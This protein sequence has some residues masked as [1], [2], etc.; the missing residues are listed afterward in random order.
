MFIIF[1]YTCSKYCCAAGKGSTWILSRL[2]LIP[3]YYHDSTHY[4]PPLI[5]ALVWAMT[6]TKSFGLNYGLLSYLRLLYIL[7]S[8][9]LTMITVVQPCNISSCCLVEKDSVIAT[10][11]IVT[12]YTY[13][14]IRYNMITTTEIIT[15]LKDRC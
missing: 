5:T 4:H 9:L 10:L 3:L 6:D 8:I 12:N 14:V 7:H 2:N 1:T 15:E 13:I 11:I